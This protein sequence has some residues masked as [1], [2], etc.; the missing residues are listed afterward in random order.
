MAQKELDRLVNSATEEQL[1]DI[2]RGWSQTVSFGLLWNI[3]LIR[4]LTG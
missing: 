3:R 2:V 4:R 1:R